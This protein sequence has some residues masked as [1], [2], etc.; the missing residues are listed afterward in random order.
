ML[1]LCLEFAL[2]LFVELD[3]CLFAP[4]NISLEP[5]LLFVVLD[6]VK[7]LTSDMVK[8]VPVDMNAGIES[9][10]PGPDSRCLIFPAIP[11]TASIAECTTLAGSC[12]FSE[13]D[14]F[15]R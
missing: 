4:W 10:C 8:S 9:L 5:S 14:C 15:L 6:A 13:N 1:K 11:D 12:N 2:P 7:L 3:P